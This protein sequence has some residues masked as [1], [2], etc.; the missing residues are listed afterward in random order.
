MPETSPSTSLTPIL[1][2][3]VLPRAHKK[4][5][6]GFIIGIL[7][8]VGSCLV[9]QPTLA[10]TDKS[11]D[12]MTSFALV[13]T[14]LALT[15]I[16][17]ELGHVIAGWLVGFRFRMINL[18]PLSLG[19]EHGRLRM[20]WRQ[21]MFVGS[22]GMTTQSMRS[23]HRRL[24]IFV[25]GGPAA[26]IL[27]IPAAVLL[28]N[29]LLP[30]LTGTSLEALAAQFAVFSL[31]AGFA[32]LA[33]LR[34][35]VLSDGAR[36]ELLIRGGSRARRW[37]T[38]EAIQRLYVRG[39]R[40]R[41]WKSTWVRAASSAPDASYDAFAGEWLAYMWASDRKDEAV[42][43]AHIEK[44]LECASTL[45]HFAREIL[46]QEASIVVAWWRNDADLATRWLTQV[47][48]PR[49][50]RRLNRIRLDVAL[51]CARGQYDAA[52]NFW[53]EGFAFIAADTEGVAKRMLTESWSEWRA[54]IQDRQAQTAL[55]FN[56]PT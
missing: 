30:N 1:D 23:M 34:S 19:R 13:V 53:T 12:P 29:H 40:A 28:V 48:S 18:G 38:L 36:I 26:N 39:T 21:G 33:P 31:V 41:R 11:H 47:K 25:M 44:C 8:L 6:G 46:A 56:G 52:Q 43:A 2:S 14:A 27:S 7:V 9:L 49:S 10:W 55:R 42:A 5:A 45:P 35:S 50:V 24:L 16:V 20:G 15:V 17:H 4:S 54:E 51:S 32:N 3:G 37:L 22:T